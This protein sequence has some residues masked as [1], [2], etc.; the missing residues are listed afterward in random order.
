MLLISFMLIF[1]IVCF[2][3]YLGLLIYHYIDFNKIP[4]GRMTATLTWDLFQRMYEVNPDQYDVSFRSVIYESKRRLYYIRR[5]VSTKDWDD[6]GRVYVRFKTIFAYLKA[7]HY[8][9]N[10]KH[11]KKQDKK[12]QKEI[13][14]IEALRKLTQQDID[15]LQK[16]VDA[17]FKRVQKTV[18]KVAQGIGEDRSEIKV[19]VDKPQIYVDHYNNMTYIKDADG[20]FVPFHRSY[21]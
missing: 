7:C 13:E 18:E 15:N 8:F 6:S 21:N 3:I 2:A 10:E 20:K 9:T 14:G 16:K 11:N 12:N 1:S 4:D 5:T 19:S 17:D